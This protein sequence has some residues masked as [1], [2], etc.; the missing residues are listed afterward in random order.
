MFP[1]EKRQMD[2]SKQPLRTWEKVYWGV[3]VTGF[4]VFLLSRVSV[5]TS[6]EPEDP[7]IAERREESRMRAARLM[8]AGQPPP[9]DDPFDGLTPQ[10]I[11]QYVDKATNG[12]TSEDPFEGMSPEEINNFMQ[13]QGS[14]ATG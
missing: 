10:E 4:S 6:A 3:F 14:T 2:G 5:W 8:L 9:A 1:W 12:A 13:Q 11:Q 7:A